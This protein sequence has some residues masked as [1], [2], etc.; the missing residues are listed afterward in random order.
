[1]AKISNFTKQALAFM[2]GDTDGVI[3]KQ[4]ERKANS[5]LDGQIAVLKG[6]IV[7]Q[8]ETVNDKKEALQKAKYPATR[9]DNRESYLQNIR[10]AQEN[11]DA[12]EDTLQDTRD[13]I[14]YW[15]GLLKEYA[16]QVDAPAQEAKA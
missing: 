7:D 11:L 15:E 14:S 8:E 4:N 13:S 16:E 10:Y 6:K 2:S 5:A 9:I 12:A 3:A 1:M